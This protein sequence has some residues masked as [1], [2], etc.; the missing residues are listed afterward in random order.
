MSNRKRKREELKKNIYEKREYL[1]PENNKDY[2][3]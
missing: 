1:T 3:P 2:K